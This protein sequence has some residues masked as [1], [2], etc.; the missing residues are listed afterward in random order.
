M[1]GLIDSAYLTS[2]DAPDIAAAT[3]GA[4]DVACLYQ[5]IVRLADGAVDSAE[6]LV[7]RRD[8]DGAL[9]GAAQ[10]AEALYA[11]DP[12]RRLT[13]LVVRA[14]IDDVTAGR[15]SGLP[16][17]YMLNLPLHV[18]LDPTL[19]SWIDRALSDAHISPD[20][21]GFELTETRPVEDFAEAAM[22]ITALR[23]QG[24]H[25]AL[26]DITDAT[27]DLDRLFQLDF[28]AVKLDCSVVAA[29]DH[30][31]AAHDFVRRTVADCAATGKQLI[32]EGAEDP[33]MLVRLHDLGVG[34]AQGFI[35]ARPLTA[36]ALRQW[37]NGWADNALFPVAG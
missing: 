27:A 15:L 11:G 17:L 1:D 24:H 2:F 10:F 8:Q 21:L 26:D 3:F 4:A 16:F 9:Q 33:A 13:G 36:P 20:R 18:L 32:A 23:S 25:V 31:S 22:A 5:P 19:P 37:F 14:V 35:I 28:N 29:L 12:A 6:I 30:S 34:Y 7:R